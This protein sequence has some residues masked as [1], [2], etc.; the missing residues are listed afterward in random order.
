MLSVLGVAAYS[1]LGHAA[2]TCWHESLSS[3]PL[4][5]RPAALIT[6]WAR[7]CVCVSS[8]LLVPLLLPCRVGI[9]S[10]AKSAFSINGGTF[11]AHA[12]NVVVALL[13]IVLTRLPIVSYHFQV[14]TVWGC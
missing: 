3:W 10:I 7:P 6:E 13:Q 4:H 11:M 12:G 9:V 1:I 2:A 5:V 14:S 8:P